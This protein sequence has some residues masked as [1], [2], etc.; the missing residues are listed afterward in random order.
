M[1]AISRHI[2]SMVNKLSVC[3]EVEVFDFNAGMRYNAAK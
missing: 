1:P 3:I 2:V